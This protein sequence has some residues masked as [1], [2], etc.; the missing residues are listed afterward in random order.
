VTNVKPA[1]TAMIPACE[2]LVLNKRHLLAVCWGVL[3]VCWPCFSAHGETRPS[4]KIGAVFS[5]TGKNSTIGMAN[6]NTVL[7]VADQINKTGG[8]NGF[9]L[10]VLLEDDQTLESG[11]KAAV[12]KF[13]DTDKVFAI[14]GPCISGNSL[15]VK[16]M[17]ETK[18]IPMVSSAA[19]EAIVE[20]VEES[21][22][23]FKTTQRD[24]HAV[25]RILEQIKDMGI[26]KIAI[27]CETTPFGKQGQNHLKQLAPKLGIEIAVDETFGPTT[28]TMLP[29]LQRIQ[30]SGVGAVVNWSVVPTQ[31][32]IPREM[33]K[34]GISLPLFHSHGFGTPKNVEICGSA[35]EGIV[36][37]QG[38]LPIAEQLPAGHFQKHVLAEY[39]KAYQK[40][41]GEPATT[42][43]AQ[44]HDAI[45]LIV[46]AIKTKNITPSMDVETARSLIRDGIE[47]TSA[48][49]GTGGIFNMSP[50]DHVGLDKDRSLDMLEVRGGKIVPLQFRK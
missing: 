9:P 20:P 21:K 48:W 24:S 17:C 40:A 18:R 25:M 47:E 10:E 42:F 1:Q 31:T 35:C 16:T 37:P 3:F 8:I 41:F 29:Q 45:W 38:R 19:A 11:A 12:Q 6:K 49:I 46:N 43:G 30:A 39:Q 26:T 22:F 36:F 32:I 7:L 27:I 33:K 5:V 2:E 44:G 15:A 23:V 28:T 13:I 50:A 4:L 34:L 14:V